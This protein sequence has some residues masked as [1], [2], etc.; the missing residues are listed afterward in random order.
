[1]KKPLFQGACTALVTPF[2]DDKVNYPMLEQLIR[3]QMEAGIPA[4]VLCGTTGEAPTLSDT[5]KLEIFRRG[6]ACAGSKCKIIAGTG[7]N[8]TAHAVALSVAAEQTGVDALLVV[9]PYYNKA[10]A[11]GLYAHYEAIA[12]NVRIPV[13]LYN[14]P[15]RTGVDIPI[16]VY[17]RLSRI[18]NIIGVKEASPDITKIQKIIA[19]CG[20]DFH[21]WSG[22]DDQTVPVISLGGQGVISVTSNIAPVQVQAMARAALDGDL[23]TAAALQL[24]LLPLNEV[25]FCQVNPIPVKAAM[26]MIGYDCG[27]CR[28]PLTP[29][30]GDHA[31]ALQQVLSERKPEL[32]NP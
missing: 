31:L 1:M 26:G 10:T 18:P 3:R 22:N 2:L 14:V 32:S 9:S 28:L 23:D 8:C 24:R 15:S 16:S 21:I 13:I 4:V 7:S 27:S 25:M 5:E 20:P 30:S 12:R 29:L 17:R 11:D 6:K 19:S